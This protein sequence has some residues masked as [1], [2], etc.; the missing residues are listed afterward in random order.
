MKFGYDETEEGQL[1]R[2]ENV[3]IKFKGEKGDS[4]GPGQYDPKI[5]G[6]EKKKALQWEKDRVE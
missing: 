3:E 1:R 5:V 4:V 6:A 2:H